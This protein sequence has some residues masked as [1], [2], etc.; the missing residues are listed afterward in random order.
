MDLRRSCPFDLTFQHGLDLL[1]NG[2]SCSPRQHSYEVS[3]AQGALHSSDS[4]TAKRSLTLRF[5]CDLCD[6]RLQIWVLL[7]SRSF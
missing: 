3:N 4:C 2:I 1:Y 5:W 7:I 6:Q